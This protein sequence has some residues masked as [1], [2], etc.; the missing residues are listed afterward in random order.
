[1]SPH[2][3]PSQY[4]LEVKLRKEEEVEFPKQEQ[5]QEEQARERRTC[6][7]LLIGRISDV[8]SIVRQFQEFCGEETESFASL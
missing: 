2:K 5:E 7:E 8:E 4:H 3:T 1:V 6:Q